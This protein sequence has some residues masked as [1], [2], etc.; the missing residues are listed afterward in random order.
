M[1]IMRVVWQR[2]VGGYVHCVLYGGA[3]DQTKLTRCGPLT[4]REVDWPEVY[5]RLA[6]IAEMFERQERAGTPD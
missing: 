2:G 3:G 4:F 6:Q 1:Y 5:T